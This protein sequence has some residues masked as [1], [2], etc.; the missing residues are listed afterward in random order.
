[1]ILNKE[2]RDRLFCAGVCEAA[3]EASSNCVSGAQCSALSV[4]MGMLGAVKYGTA[5]VTKARP[6]WTEIGI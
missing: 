4:V 3:L 6:H 1:M 2:A 5:L